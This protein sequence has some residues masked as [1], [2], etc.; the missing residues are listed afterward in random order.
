MVD[1]KTPYSVPLIGNPLAVISPRMKA[2]K[3]SL[4]SVFVHENV[5]RFPAGVLETVLGPTYRVCKTMLRPE[6]FGFPIARDRQYC[7]CLRTDIQRHDCNFT[8]VVILPNGYFARTYLV[9]GL[10]ALAPG[11]EFRSM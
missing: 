6:Q 11:I 2:V 7:L 5:V 10:A 8:N 4:P 1:R 3:Q 9:V